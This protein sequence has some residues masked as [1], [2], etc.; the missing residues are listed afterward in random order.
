M[1]V[2]FLAIRYVPYGGLAFGETTTVVVCLAMVAGEDT[3]DEHHCNHI[4]ETVDGVGANV[5]GHYATLRPLREA[6]QTQAPQRL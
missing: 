5:A 4:Q 1:C 6:E 3:I 2:C